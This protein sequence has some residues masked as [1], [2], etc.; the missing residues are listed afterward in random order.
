MKNKDSLV[1][2]KNSNHHYVNGLKWGNDENL[3]LLRCSAFLNNV[4]LWKEMRKSDI[5]K[6]GEPLHSFFYN[7]SQ[8]PSV[9]NALLAYSSLKKSSDNWVKKVKTIE[10]SSFEAILK[11]DFWEM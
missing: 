4:S 11:E 6:D 10:K 9:E 3:K 5:G 1:K 7:L 2:L 8:K